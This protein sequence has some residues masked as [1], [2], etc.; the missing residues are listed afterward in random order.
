MYLLTSSCDAFLFRAFIAGC[1]DFFAFVSKRAV[2]EV[3]V[4]FSGSKWKI[5]FQI[6]DLEHS[7]ISS[8][9]GKYNFQKKI[10]SKVKMN[11]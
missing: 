2:I 7:V 4:K 9:T 3:L 8:D 10:Q 5:I 6:H 1:A 11:T